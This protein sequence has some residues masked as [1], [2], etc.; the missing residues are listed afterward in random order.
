MLLSNGIS[1]I[2]ICLG[3]STGVLV[4]CVLHLLVILEKNC[5]YSSTANSKYRY[6]YCYCKFYEPIIYQYLEKNI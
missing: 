3:F 6:K 4:F 5:L 2:Y 1:Y